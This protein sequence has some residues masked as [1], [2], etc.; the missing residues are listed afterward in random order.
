MAELTKEYGWGVAE[1]FASIVSG[2]PISVGKI[3]G[4]V[5]S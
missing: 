2:G 5:F 4:S 3:N 1:L